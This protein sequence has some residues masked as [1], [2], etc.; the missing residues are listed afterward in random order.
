[1]GCSM[2]L[3]IYPCVLGMSLWFRRLRAPS[4][5]IFLSHLALDQALL[6]AD[7]PEPTLGLF[8]LG[9]G[10]FETC[11][12][13]DCISMLTFAEWSSLAERPVLLNFGCSYSA[14]GLA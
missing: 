1:M 8:A 14:K 10:V 3:P 4:L 5:L 11:Q 2:S 7:P 9:L 6:A 12:A 13:L